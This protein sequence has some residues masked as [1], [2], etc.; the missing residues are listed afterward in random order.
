ML[1]LT[2]MQLPAPSQWALL[3]LGAEQGVVF[4]ESVTA[5]H[6]PVAGKHVPAM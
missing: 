3:A 1:Q 5:E 4:G 6:C 2:A